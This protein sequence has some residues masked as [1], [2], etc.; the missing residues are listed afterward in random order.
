MNKIL[1]QNKQNTIAF[2]IMCYEGNQKKV[3]DLY[4][5]S[6]Y[7]QHNPLVGNGIQLF[8]AYFDKMATEYPNKSI[9][10]RIIASY[11]INIKKF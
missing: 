8:I 6:E 9:D 1:K 2:Y 7:I 4:I 5:G 10:I 3:T 11:T